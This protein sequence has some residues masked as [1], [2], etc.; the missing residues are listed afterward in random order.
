MKS[1]FLVLFAVAAVFATTSDYTLDEGV[2]VLTKDNF[3]KAL[4]EFEFALVEFY[5]PWCGH[6]QRLAPE[7]AEAAQKLADSNPEIKLCKVNAEDETDLAEKY[8]IGGFPTLKFLIK[9][10]EEPIE[11]TGG[12]TASDIIAWLKKKTSSPTVEVNSVEEAQKQFTDNEVV[13]FFFGPTTSQAFEDFR[14]IATR[15]DDVFFLNSNADEVKQKYE[16][17]DESILLFIENGSE[18]IAFSG[19]LN[20]ENINNFINKNRFPLVMPFNQAAA[21]RIFGEELDAVFLIKADNDAGNKAVA[22]FKQVANEFKDSN[23]VFSLAGIEEDFGGKLAEFIGVEEDQLPAVRIVQPQ[24]NLRKYQ[25]SSE[26]TAE[27]LKSFINDFL[28]NKLKPFFRSQEIPA[29]PF[30]NNVRIVVANNFEEVVLDSTKDV[31]I[32][33][34]APWC[35]HCQ[36]LAPIYESLAARLKE[37]TNIVIAKMDATANEVESVMIEGFP[38]IKFYP[39]NNK[40][41][42]IDYEGERIESAF[43]DFIKEHATVTINDSK[44]ESTPEAQ[45]ETTQKVKDIDL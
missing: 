17:K 41:S 9:G 24:Y 34:Y 1:L 16:T 31:L 30:E 44:T 37:N 21:Q 45:D 38:T 15:F 18:K 6:C 25:F 29:E 39:S 3:D 11:Y 23:I 7:Y 19:E 32:E 5:A 35:G 27:N 40:E 10:N 13:A 33:Y 26:L 43:I 14:K 2:Y 42:P 20:A 8:N 22:A 36:S 28:N 4:N 12:R